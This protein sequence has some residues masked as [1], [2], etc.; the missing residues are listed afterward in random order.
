MLVSC[1]DREYLGEGGSYSLAMTVDTE[2]SLI[3]KSTS[4]FIEVLRVELP[5][6]EPSEARLD[7]LASSNLQ[8]YGRD[9]WVRRDQF[10]LELDWVLHNLSEQDVD[11][12]LQIN[13]FNEFHEYLPAI[14]LIA[15]ALI[16]DPSQYEYR[17]VLE[18]MHT[19]SG[20]VREEHFDEMAVDLA[21][22]AN[23]SA[24]ATAE[25]FGGIVPSGIVLPSSHSS[26]DTRAQ[27]FIP[28]QV[29]AL[30]GVRIALQTFAPL[31]VVCE[32]TLRVRDSSSRIVARAN[33][34]QLPTPTPYVPS[35]EANAVLNGPSGL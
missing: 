22:M 25:E 28:K 4:I 34:W 20:T 5:L 1:T 7:A 15:D 16:Q 19:V 21:T 33:A 30:T 11:V 6:R 14:N 2:A 12:A 9:P 29:A 13:A 31:S 3:G 35:I 24:T 23:W 10:H 17:V 27:A 32:F 8:P 26:T 18:A